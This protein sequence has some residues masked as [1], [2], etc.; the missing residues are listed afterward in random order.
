MTNERQDDHEETHEEMLTLNGKDFPVTITTT[1]T[2]P[3]EITVD[4]APTGG[5]ERE[6]TVD[7]TPT[8]G[9]GAAADASYDDLVGQAFHAL[10]RLY[11]HQ[12]MS[13]EDAEARADEAVGN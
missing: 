8:G 6:I 4:I 3:R 5:E 7:I 1:K 13:Q 12:G 11:K 10:V 9:E 2:P